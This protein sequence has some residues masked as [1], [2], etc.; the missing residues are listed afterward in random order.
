VP[1]WQGRTTRG[2]TLLGKPFGLPLFADRLLEA[3]FTEPE[4]HTM[5]VVNSRAVAA[6]GSA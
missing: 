3:G 5:A 1:S 2:S 4:A 6:A